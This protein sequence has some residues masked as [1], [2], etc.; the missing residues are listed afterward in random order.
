LVVTALGFLV[1]GACVLASARR[2]QLAVGA[3][4]VDPTALAAALCTGKDKQGELWPAL[5]RE[6]VDD[7][8]ADWERDL[9]AALS[10]VGPARIALVNEQLAELDYLAQRW[11]RVPRVC[12]S[13]STSF[14][15]LLAFATV[16]SMAGGDLDFGVAAVSAINAVAIGLAGAAFCVAAHLRARAIVRARLK[17]ADRLVE[18]LEDL[19]PASG[20]VTPAER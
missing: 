2:L 10:A 15:F 1:F 11:E 6:L 4:A 13:V 19:S 18:C 9:L 17:A 16:A 7:P 5:Q 14:G 8:E 20:A 12:A 3:S